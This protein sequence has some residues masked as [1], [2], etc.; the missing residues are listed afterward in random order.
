MMAHR[1]R[2]SRH[3]EPDMRPTPAPGYCVVG[4]MLCEVRTWTEAEWAAL[5]SD[6]RPL[7]YEHAPGLGWIGAIPAGRKQ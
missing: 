4:E 7:V 3:P 6:L 2:V 5:P 1:N